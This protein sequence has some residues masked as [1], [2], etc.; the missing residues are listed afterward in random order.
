[1]S[2]FLSKVLSQDFQMEKL[3]ILVSVNCVKQVNWKQ[4][5]LKIS[6]QLNQAM[7]KPPMR[8]QKYKKL[9]FKLL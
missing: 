7:D 8:S 4:Q 1:M 3:K 5:T 9:N 6:N 2:A